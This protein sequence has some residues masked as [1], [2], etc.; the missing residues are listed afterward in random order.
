LYLRTY[1][2]FDK[3][4]RSIGQASKAMEVTHAK[5][6]ISNFKRLLGRRYHDTYVQLEKEINS[7]AIVEGN[8]GTVNIEV[9]TKQHL[10][11]T[12][13]RSMCSLGRLSRR[14]QTIH[15]RANH[16][17]Y[18]HQVETNHRH[19]IENKSGGLC[20]RSKKSGFTD[21]T[22]KQTFVCL[23]VGTLLFHGY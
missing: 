19:G 14:T 16:R 4:T 18:V 15:T 10:I 2:T 12:T 3:S 5:N 11:R 23:F 8:H 13:D 17:D 6:T 9:S 7:Y 1:I 20:H 22:E 21:V